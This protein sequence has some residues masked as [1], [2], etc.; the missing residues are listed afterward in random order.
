MSILSRNVRLKPKLRIS[1][2][3]KVAIGTWRDAGD[4]SVYGAIEIDAGKAL[5]WI[6]Q[7]RVKTGVKVTMTHFVGVAIARCIRKHPAINC[8]LRWGTLY[9]RENVDVFFQVATDQHGQ[10][11]SGMVIRNADRKTPVEIAKEMEAKVID[12]REKGDKDYKQMKGTI[13]MLPGMLVGPFLT[14]GG[15]LLYTLNLWGSWLGSP[16]DSFG[17]C[18]VTSVGGLGLDMGFAPLVPYSRCPFLIA[19]GAV[20]EKPWAVDGKVEVRPI[21]R[22]CATFDHRLVDGVHAAHMVR[23]LRAFFSDPQSQL[24]L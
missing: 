14:L 8:V 20:Q 3:R 23:E 22:L 2:W 19:V 5:E 4:P 24:P 6:E 11:L 16:Q 15:F 12:I 17:S 21:L 10:D 18:M 7:V 9:Q 1:S 13:G